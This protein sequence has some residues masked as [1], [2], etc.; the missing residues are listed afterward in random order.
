MTLPGPLVSGKLGNVV[1]QA[2]LDRPLGVSP[3]LKPGER[4]ID[5]LPPPSL[6]TLPRSSSSL[7]V[8]YL[9]VNT[10]TASAD[11]DACCLFLANEMMIS[12]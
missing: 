1:I 7:D 12:G 10:G 8:M 6:S 11:L 5:T 2:R 9:T 3:A 4:K